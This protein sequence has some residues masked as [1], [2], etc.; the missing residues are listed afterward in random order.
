M[1][2][3]GAG[4]VDIRLSLTGSEHRLWAYEVAGLRLVSDLPISQLTPFASDATVAGSRDLPASDGPGDGVRVYAGPGWVGGRLR[5]VES[6]RASQGYLLKIEGAGDFEV[7]G[8]GTRVGRRQPVENGAPGEEVAAA[9]LGPCLVLAL[10]LRGIW[11]LHASAASSAGSAV[12]LAGESGCGKSTV[13]AALANGEEDWRRIADDL[14]PVKIENGAAKALPHYPQPGAVAL[15]QALAEEPQE[16]SL[17]VV[18][19]LEPG[20]AAVEVRQLTRRRA[21]LALVR[22]TM[23]ARL[24]DAELQARHLDFCAET[25]RCLP[26]RSLCF[27]RRLAA[28]ASMTATIVAG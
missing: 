2:G 13:A 9:V 16:V 25:A 23:A 5:H 21:A 20:A 8:D 7:S 17:A 15:S 28:L 19:L 10:A 22:Q 11:C 12:A 24:F 4:I 1:L 3:R 18:Y 6:R 26:V 27:P 14:L